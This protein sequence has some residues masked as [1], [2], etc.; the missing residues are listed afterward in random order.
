MSESNK[1]NDPVVVTC[2]GNTETWESRAEAMAFYLEAMAASEGSECERYK[3]IYI[4][5]AYGEKNCFIISL[6]TYWN[7]LGDCANSKNSDGTSH[8]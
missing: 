1:K 6:P 4:A 5:L 8:F 7:W 3:N 2:Y